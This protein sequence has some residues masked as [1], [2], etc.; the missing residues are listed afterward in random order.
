VD[1]HSQL[2]IV[3]DVITTGATAVACAEALSAAGVECLGIVSFART[4]PLAEPG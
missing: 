2:L 4:D 3:D 1:P